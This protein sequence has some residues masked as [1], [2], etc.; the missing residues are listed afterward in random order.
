MD[1]F[2]HKH[3]IEIML[4]T[5]LTDKAPDTW[6]KIQWMQF[7]QSFRRTTVTP[8]TF[9]GRVWQG[10]SSTVTY[11][12]GRRVKKNMDAAWHMMFDFDDET[13]ASSLE[14][15]TRP[16]SFASMF[17]SFAYSTPSS[18]PT[19]PRSRV[20]FVFNRPITDIQYY[21]KLYAAIAWRFELDGSKIDEAC[22]D[23]LHIFAGSKEADMVGVWSVVT[24]AADSVTDKVLSDWLIEQ[25]DIAHPPPPLPDMSMPTRIID[26]PHEKWQKAMILALADNIA[27]APDGERHIAR[28]NNSRT[29]G[30]YIASGALSEGDVMHALVMAARYNTDDPDAAERTVRD[31]IE[32]GKKSPLYP[33]MVDRAAAVVGPESLQKKYSVKLAGARL[34]S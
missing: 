19:A 16:G 21:K 30:G 12:N 2:K 25:Y 1:T 5:M 26:S 23:P 14:Y 17:A 24:T 34:L 10:F 31:G 4:S 27:K 6:G 15:L 20:V 32:Y 18:T 9:A 28:R 11:N 33:E 22:K 8:H 7:N 29:A 3:K 13:E